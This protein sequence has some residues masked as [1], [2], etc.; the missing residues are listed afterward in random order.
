M[1]LKLTKKETESYTVN[2]NDNLYYYANFIGKDNFL[3]YFEITSNKYKDKLNQHLLKE[4]EEE[5]WLK[6]L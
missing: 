1:K 6:K 5:Q 3:E 4:Q 2:K